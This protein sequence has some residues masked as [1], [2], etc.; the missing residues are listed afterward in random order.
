MQFFTLVVLHAAKLTEPPV[1]PGI[2]DIADFGPRTR[3]IRVES[4]QPAGLQTIEGVLPWGQIDPNDAWAL[5][6]PLL[7]AEPPQTCLSFAQ[8][9]LGWSDRW[10]NATEV[11]D[12][13]IRMATV[14]DPN[15]RDRVNDLKS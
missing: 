8:S 4:I 12:R 15:L 9:I 2:L 5:A 1:I 7:E 3:Q 14:R 11:A 13:A 6:Q 10:E